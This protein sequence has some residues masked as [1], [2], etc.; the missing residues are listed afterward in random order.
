MYFWQK[1][2]RDGLYTGMHEELLD[3]M[4]E[5]VCTMKQNQIL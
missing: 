2:D 1:N 3:A 5:L 4:F